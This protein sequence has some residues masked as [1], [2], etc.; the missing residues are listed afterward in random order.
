VV[1]RRKRL[2][3]RTPDLLLMVGAMGL[4]RTCIR[5]VRRAIRLNLVTTPPGA[6]MG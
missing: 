5:L 4:A 2:I 6:G 1:G 3:Q